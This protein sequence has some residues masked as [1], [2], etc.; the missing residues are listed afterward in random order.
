MDELTYRN[1]VELV[2][3][4][5]QRSNTVMR[6]AISP[7]ERL[8]ATLRFLAT[9]RSY[10]DL[11]FFTCISKPAL[12]LIVPESCGVRPYKTNKRLELDVMEFFN[13]LYTDSTLGEYEN[14]QISSRSDFWF[15]SYSFLK[16]RESWII[17]RVS[18]DSIVHN[19]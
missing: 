9:G 10:E 14:P 1:P 8:S 18:Q 11:K 2:A 3:P 12:S 15:S 13:F 17:D 6:E 7:N 5:V 19:F 16:I 4:M